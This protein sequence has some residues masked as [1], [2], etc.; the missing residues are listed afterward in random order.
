MVFFS[1][2][3]N[4][5]QYTQNNEWQA[6]DNASATIGLHHK[7]RQ[8]PHSNPQDYKKQSRHTFAFP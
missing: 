1:V 8:A 7:Q 2:P 4:N 3:G 5:K 6:H